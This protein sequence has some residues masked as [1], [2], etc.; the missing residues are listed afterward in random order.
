[1]SPGTARCRAASTAR[2]VDT[3][4]PA[5]EALRSTFRRDLE[6]LKAAFGIEA[7]YDAQEGR[8]ELQPPFF[9][10]GRAAGPDRGV[11]GGGGEHRGRT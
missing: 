9:S 3:S 8:Y 6:A 7:R 1:M 2:F 4:T 5:H 11:G 10:R